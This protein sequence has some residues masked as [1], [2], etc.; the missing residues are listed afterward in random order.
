MKILMIL[1]NPFTHDPR[2]YNEAKSLIKVGHDVTILAWDKKGNNK[3]EEEKDKI[4]IIRSFN[5]KFMKILPYDILRL[6]HWWKKGFKD[7]VELFEK[8]DFDIIH[9]HNLDTLP[10]GIKL[11]KKYGKPLVYDAHEIWGYMV[12]KDLPGWW[13]NYYL[14]KEKKI[15]QNADKI[16]TVNEPLKDY[17]KNITKKP[18]KIVMNCKNLEDKEYKLTDNKKF[19]LLYIG[20]LSKSRFLIETVETVKE[21]PEVKLI[22]GGIGKKVYIEQLIKLCSKIKNI[23]FIGIVPT[24]KVIPMTKKADV[25][26]C[27]FDPNNKNNQ[28]G[29]PNKVFEAAVCGRPLIVTKGLYYEKIVVEKNRFGISTE[30]NKKSLKEAILKLKNDKTLCEELGKN[31]L[32][33]AEKEY[34]WDKQKEKLLEVYSDLKK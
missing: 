3:A 8:K 26:I 12:S 4:K 32:R 14:K 16:I 1:S 6:H 33:A 28:V 30:Y 31:A 19:T 25:V 5:S 23:D 9:C 15:I 13:A 10:I 7:A 17:F 2:V 29:L 27:I 24:E 20:V 22:I 18:I 11:K 21:I 34:N